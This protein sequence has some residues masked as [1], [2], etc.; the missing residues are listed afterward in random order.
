MVKWLASNRARTVFLVSVLIAASVLS[1]YAYLSSLTPQ[2][3]PRATVV[4]PPVEFWMELDKTEYAYGE[5]MTIT[6]CLENIS[7]ETITVFKGSIWPF[8]PMW[9]D[10]LYTEAEGVGGYVNDVF[11]FRFSVA[12]A[13]GTEI[14]KWSTGPL[15]EA[16]SLVFEPGGYVKQRFIY[17]LY[18]E[19]SPTQEPGFYYLP[20]G[21]YQIR[22][23]SYTDRNAPGGITTIETAPIQFTI[24]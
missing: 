2:G 17:L 16:Y 9:T 23:I 3:G 8:D 22:G 20:S 6:F 18:Y 5:N 7:N 21:S 15:P 13:N 11:H 4:S 24:E 10:M 19:V 14:F 1:V 12:F